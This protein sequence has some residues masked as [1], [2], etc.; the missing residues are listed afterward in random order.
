MFGENNMI[1]ESNMNVTYQ[2]NMLD[3]LKNECKQ[4]IEDPECVYKLCDNKWLV[5]M[6][7]LPD[8]ITN[9]LRKDVKNANNAKF[10]ANKLNVLKIINVFDGTTT[11]SILN[12]FNNS[13]VIYIVDKDVFPNRYDKNP[14]NICSCGIHYFKTIDAA[15]YYQ[16]N[17]QPNFSG[18]WKVFC[19]S[20]DV[21]KEKYYVN[22]YEKTENEIANIQ[23]EIYTNDILTKKSEQRAII[24]S[25][26]RIVDGFNDIVSITCPPIVLS[27]GRIV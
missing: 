20:G 21:S 24:L 7:K 22:G 6:K 5:I 16:K 26:G 27:D 19:D 3:H 9:E 1:T 18:V 12:Q 8:T 14:N 4:Y 23:K 25:D 13:S 17:V 10:R 15:F 2:V 11:Q